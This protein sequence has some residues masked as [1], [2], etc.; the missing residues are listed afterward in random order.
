MAEWGVAISKICFRVSE[1]HD[2]LPSGATPIADQIR[3]AIEL[4]PPLSLIVVQD[5]CDATLSLE[6]EGEV[7]SAWYSGH[8]LFAGA[9]ATGT[10]Q[11]SAA[12]KTTLTHR[13]DGRIEPPSTI[14]YV[15][16]DDPPFSTPD[17][18]PLWGTVRSD[19]VD[20]VTAWF[21]PEFADLHGT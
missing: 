19:F 15:E 17:E 13:L 7:I 4:R 11:L 3:A 2:G 12:G 6:V 10:L 5:A 1:R 8:T 14:T 9:A 18:A 20:A 21:G 16:G